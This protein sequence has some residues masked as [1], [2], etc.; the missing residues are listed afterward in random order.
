MNKTE[1]KQLINE[2]VNE[3]E[4]N[5]SNIIDNIEEKVELIDQLKLLEVFKLYDKNIDGTGIKVG[6]ID[7]N[8]M[9]IDNKLSFK[10]IYSPT[11]SVTESYGHGTV[12]SSLI[13]G[14]GLGVA[15]GCELYACYSPGN[16]DVNQFNNINKCLRWCIDNNMD[17][18]SISQGYVPV[19]LGKEYIEP[20]KEMIKLIKEADEKNIII[21]AAAGN[22]GE[23]ANV[24]SVSIPARFL[25][26]IGVGAVDMNLKLASFSS[27]GKGV[28]F[29][30]LGEGIKVFDKY[31]ELINI[32]IGGTSYSTPMIAGL[33]ALMLQ[34]NRNLKRRDIVHLL[35]ENAIVLSEE[36]YSE[37][38]GY[39]FPVAVSVPRN[40]SLLDKA[41][42][43][44]IDTE[45]LNEI[46]ERNNIVIEVP[47]GVGQEFLFDKLNIAELHK[48]NIKGQGIKI[49]VV[50]VGCTNVPD[51][52]IKQYIDFSGENKL[53]VEG[54]KD[55]GNAITSLIASKSI[56]I[57]PEA[58]IY[59]LRTFM[60]SG[61]NTAKNVNKAV[62]WCINNK[63]DIVLVWQYTPLDLI[64]KLSDMGTI[65]IA[66]S[67]YNYNETG[68]FAG[69]ASEDKNTVSVTFVT[70]E[71]GFIT[72][73]GFAPYTSENV[74]CAAYGYGFNYL[75]EAGNIVEM[76]GDVIKAVLYR[77]LFAAY[78]VAGVLALIK[79]QNPEI[80]NA[81][82]V[83]GI[84]SSICRPLFTGGKN[85]KVGYGVI[86]AKLYK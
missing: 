4:N 63:V 29:V 18:I 39:G 14:K 75:N 66:P 73:K 23:K 41:W 74:D 43:E 64:K 35:S 54:M 76:K 27:V 24:N 40:Y 17:I 7:T 8:F 46:I 86:K 20:V 65:V 22:D 5:L 44:D 57:T 53:W 3:L 67:I 79:Q 70:P 62:N 80:N 71:D 36:K 6:V 30:S 13:A 31:G 68:E 16:V 51:F 81:V 33:I 34:Q 58:E 61:W 21:V 15:P 2:A 84:L 50:G 55:I 56:G 37:K 25:E 1:I 85:E 77:T 47:I 38:T 28:E 60:S 32:D 42:E 10:N 49:A 9:N 69:Y 78:Q 59:V 72:D 19:I 45:I 83:R 48:A 11:G 26:C 52:N 12:C 82:K